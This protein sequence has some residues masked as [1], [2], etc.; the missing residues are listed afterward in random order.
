[1]FAIERETAQSA[2]DVST[3]LTETEKE[4]IRRFDKLSPAKQKNV[5]RLVRIILNYSGPLDDLNKWIDRHSGLTDKE[6]SA[7]IDKLE[8]ELGA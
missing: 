3:P 8:Q 7:A 4:F 5:L 2:A 6:L 1:M